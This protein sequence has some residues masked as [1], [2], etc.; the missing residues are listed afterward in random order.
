MLW[1]SGLGERWGL[2]SPPRP[3]GRTE[4]CTLRILR[5]LFRCSR[6]RG[7][8]GGQTMQGDVAPCGTTDRDAAAPLLL[9]HAGSAFRSPFSSISSISWFLLHMQSFSVWSVFS[10]DSSHAGSAFRSPFSVC[11]VCSVVS[12][13]WQSCAQRLLVYFEY[14]VVSPLTC[15]PF[16][17]YS[18][19][20]VVSFLHA[21][22][23]V[24][25]V[26]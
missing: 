16:S 17:V 22:L 12:P 7:G 10:V 9:P 18:V 6:G 3:S 5:M 21:V 14:F 24:W 19:C 2:A 11:S 23:F 4:S 8:E 20:S 25:S 1:I 26:F 13:L 15:C